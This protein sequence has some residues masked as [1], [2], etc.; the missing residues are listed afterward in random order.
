VFH[1]IRLAFVAVLLAACSSAPASTSSPLLRSADA[2]SGS[3]A[4]APPSAHAAAADAHPIAVV[5]DMDGGGT[6]ILVSPDGER[7]QLIAEA[8][9]P[10]IDFA[11]VW[12]P[13]GRR[14]AH[15]R[16]TDGGVAE[17]HVTD[18]ATGAS[19]R[20]A[21]VG[22]PSTTDP[23]VSWSPNGSRLAYWSTSG[24]DN[25]IMVV[26]S[27]GTGAP[28]ALAADPGADRYPAWSPRD[29]LVAFW[30][31]RSG[32]GSLW[33]ATPDGEVSLLAE[34]GALF[35]PAAWSPE[36]EAIAV[37]IEQ[38]GDVWRL[39]V[40]DLRGGT[41]AELAGESSTVSPSWSPDGARI[42]YW[43]VDGLSSRL[44]IANA[45]GSGARGI[46][47]ASAAAIHSLASHGS[48]RW[49]DPP[50]WAPDGIQVAVEWSSTD[51]VEVLLVSADTGAWRSLSPAKTNEG[52][53]A[54][55]PSDP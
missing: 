15:H 12:D 42:A 53:P 8:D 37:P 39:R 3:S 18:V 26:A 40:V 21:E 32:V 27:D 6:I 20:V 2:S 17:V 5:S 31:D 46:G 52:S 13:G 33:I 10:H 45:D 49:P 24:T 34:V 44:W 25:D 50:A 9:E 30:S 36:G 35:G 43:V 16:L 29:D 14:I 7:Q 38:A 22:P 41:L 23:R 1:V 47:P 28:T 48:V 4:F 54:W 55:R 19:R 11:P 51:G